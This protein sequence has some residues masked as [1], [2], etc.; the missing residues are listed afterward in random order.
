MKR[1]AAIEVR[2]VTRHYDTPAGLVRALDEITLQVDGASSVAITGPSGCG[3]STLLGLIAGLE[4]PTSG[5]VSVGGEEL[6]SLPES[7]RARLRREHLGLVFQADNLQPFLTATE[8]VALQLALRGVADG[9]RRSQRL[10]KELGLAKH[11]DKLPDQLSGGQRQRVAIARALI[12]EPRVILA[13]E[14]TG[15]LD[16]GNSRVIVDLLLQA[17]R[18]LGATLV[19]V[20]HDPSVAARLDR[21][22]HLR[23]GRVQDV[24]HA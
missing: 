17:R 23:D 19:V 20:T 1:P 11:A 12:D 5:R 9:Q 16:A 7:D 22:I 18:A 13:D 15:S 10:L 8:N 6:S 2:D 24:A 4:I 14:P 21:T 3:K